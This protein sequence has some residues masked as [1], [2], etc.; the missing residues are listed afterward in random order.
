MPFQKLDLIRLSSWYYS[1]LYFA[2]ATSS[3]GKFFRFSISTKE[4][5]HERIVL[6]VLLM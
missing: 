3:R 1:F 6:N 5:L 4:Q 2:Q